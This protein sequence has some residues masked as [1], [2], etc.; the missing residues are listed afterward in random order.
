ML[1]LIIVASIVAYLI[2]GTTLTRSVLRYP[3]GWFSK[4][5]FHGT[6]PFEGCERAVI[7]CYYGFSLVIPI[8]DLL[9]W[10]FIATG[11]F[12]CWL[13]RLISGVKD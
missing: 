6:W 10:F 12:W 1:M 11:R 4:D 7:A 3:L 9:G 2:V 8:L 5:M 13:C